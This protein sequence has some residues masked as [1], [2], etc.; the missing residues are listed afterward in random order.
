MKLTATTFITIDGVYQ[1]PG[2]VDED[3]SGGFTHGGWAH[4]YDDEVFGG[5]IDGVFDRADAFLLGRKTYETF[6]AFWPKVTDPANPVAGPLN[7][8]PKYVP[9]STLT[10]AEWEG[11][12]LLTGD[13]REEVTALKAQPGRELQ[14]HGSGHLVGSL[15][16]LGLVDTLHLLTFPV[17]LGSGKRLFAADVLP[18]AFALDE[19]RSTSTGV[20]IG[21]YTR[22]GAPTYGT[23]ELP[24]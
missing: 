24:E 17:L 11:T 18:S 14:V 2:G 19:T 12:H 8:L 22:V 9:T 1:A 7:R 5:F 21:T 10:S 15:L 6:A 16:A 13:L 3:R 4:P 20:V 23:Y